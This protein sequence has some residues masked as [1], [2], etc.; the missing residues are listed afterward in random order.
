MHAL[1]ETEALHTLPSSGSEH[2]SLGTQASSDAPQPSSEEEEEEEDTH[3]RRA[4]NVSFAANMW[5]AAAVRE[6]GRACTS[7]PYMVFT[8]AGLTKDECGM[9]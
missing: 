9:T 3:T 7:G 2:L 6:A 4:L 1:T 8:D 5:V